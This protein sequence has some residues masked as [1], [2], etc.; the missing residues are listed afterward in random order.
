MRDDGVY[1]DHIAE[2]LRR[3]EQY[4]GGTPGAPDSHLFYEDPRTQDAVL[5]RLETAADA[6]SHLSRE[7]KARHP[8]IPW[9]QI[10]AFR[11]ILAHGYA[12]L[13]LDQVWL[14][15][16]NDLTALRTVVDEERGSS[17]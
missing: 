5:R 10:G 11:N 8:G 14:A 9:R 15:V 12:D 16:A 6:A 7:L 1:L 4:L 13:D 17:P 3:I 2:S